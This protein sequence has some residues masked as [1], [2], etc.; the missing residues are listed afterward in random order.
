MKTVAFIAAAAL[1][2]GAGA[3]LADTL[4]N[5]AGNTVNVT[6]SEGATVRYHFDADHSFMMMLPDNQMVMGAWSVADG[7]ICLTPA[8]GEQACTEYVGDKNVGDSWTQRGIDGTQITV[9][10][11][12]G[13]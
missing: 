9:S 11:T 6:N 7:Q 13:R 5:A 3:A 8:G 12:A 4:E 2:L 1:A 10:V